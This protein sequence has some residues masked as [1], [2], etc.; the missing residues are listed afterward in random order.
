MGRLDEL[1][2]NSTE[3]FRTLTVRVTTTLADELKNKAKKLGISRTKL[4]SELFHA[5]LDE[6]K[7]KFKT[8]AESA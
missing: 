5:G 2:T 1:V 4:V 8:E 3:D 7:T 6:F